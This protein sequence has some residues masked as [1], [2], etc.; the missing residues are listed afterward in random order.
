MSMPKSTTYGLLAMGM[1]LSVVAALEISAPSHVQDE[2]VASSIPSAPERP[3]VAALPPRMSFD[4][5]P[6][7]VQLSGVAMGLGGARAALVSINS[8]PPVLV[9]IGDPLSGASTV[10]A[11]GDDWLAYT[12]GTAVVRVRIQ[13]RGTSAPAAGPNLVATAPAAPVA[14]AATQPGA[15][16]GNGNEE[17]R[18]AMKQKL[19]S[20]KP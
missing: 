16:P 8:A 12:R 10:Q 3:V 11:I 19:A 4:G 13:D 15:E 20:M 17:F 7:Q 9:R 2:F 1:V 14:L 6:L 5:P 18:Q